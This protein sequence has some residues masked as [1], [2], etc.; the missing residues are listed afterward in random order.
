MPPGKMGDMINPT[1]TA[2]CIK[3]ISRVNSAEDQGHLSE[4][5]KVNLSQVQVVR[6]EN[7]TDSLLFLKQHPCAIVLYTLADS[8]V[9]LNPLNLKEFLQRVGELHNKPIILLAPSGYPEDALR[10]I[11]NFVSGGESLPNVQWAGSSM[12]D[13]GLLTIFDRMLSSRPSFSS[14]AAFSQSQGSKGFHGI[15]GNSPSILPVFNIIERFA[16]YNA[17]VVITGETGTG[18]ELV[19]KTL[20]E[21]SPRR[22]MPFVACNCAALPENLLESELFGHTKGA[23]T[24]AIH[25][26]GGLFRHAQ[27][28]TIFLD[29]IGEM[30]LAVQ[31][32]LLRVL[33]E[34]EIRP[35]GSDQV[36]PVDIRIIVATNKDLW[37][38][39][40]AGRFR[41]DLFYRVNVAKIMLPPLRERKEDIPLLAQY[42][43]DKLKKEHRLTVKGFSTEAMRLL[44]QYDWP[45]NIRELK[46][47]MESSVMVATDELL[48]IR[49]LPPTLQAYAIK[50]QDV[51][52]KK[53]VQ[54]SPVN[55][56]E[57]NYIL[58]VLN[59]CKGNKSM[60]AL[61]LGL[62][63][64]SLYR[65]L[66]KF[67]LTA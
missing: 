53:Q 38:E 34:R 65:R 27:G 36:L 49:N 16:P 30:P 59:R 56:F 67:G 28:G 3:G 61:E 51:I 66:G 44:Q 35:L 40:E 55:S 11:K 6:K 42:F 47:S 15:I 14:K 60:A 18:K 64:R 37:E 24:G 2:L 52:L 39:V 23:F 13:L 46:N 26:R 25:Q 45:G 43:L 9:E 58:E 31:S 54:F 4:Y 29:E 57:K 62:S 10:L 32:K 63:R 17:T 22:T 1:M 12:D 48:V 41:K 7:H 19:A 21:L 33:E 5:P 50:N 20:H 8:G